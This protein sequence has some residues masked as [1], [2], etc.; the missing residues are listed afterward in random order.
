MPRTSALQNSVGPKGENSVGIAEAQ[1][2]AMLARARPANAF[3][4][5]S[6]A[7]REPPLHVAQHIPA[8]LGSLQAEARSAQPEM[9]MPADAATATPRVCRAN[10]T[11]RVPSEIFDGSKPGLQKKEFGR[12]TTMKN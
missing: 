6:H 3:G 5:S 11:S 9:G 7:P 2:A 12:N 4:V 10:V 1:S 8:T